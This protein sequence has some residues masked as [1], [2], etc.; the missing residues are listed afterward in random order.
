MRINNLLA[1]DG[2][3]SI[4]CSVYRTQSQIGISG[5]L[6]KLLLQK[7]NIISEVYIGTGIVCSYNTQKIKSEYNE[8]NPA[9]K[10]EIKN[11]I[12]KSI[13]PIPIFQF[14]LSVGIT[15]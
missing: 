7:H 2:S 13:Y 1:E 10:L 11:D 12:S 4:Y 15:K 9:Q 5:K 6:G 14:G 8:S 3:E